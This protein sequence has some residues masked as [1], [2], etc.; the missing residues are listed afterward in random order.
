MKPSWKERNALEKGIFV[1]QALCG[2]V[3][4]A[5]MLHSTINMI[6]FSDSL[7]LVI[8]IESALEAIVQWK[9]QRKAAVLSLVVT[10]S[11]IVAFSAAM[12]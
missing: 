7:Y 9:R 8:A 5:S 12:F 6:D 2:L 10:I 11:C 1:V 3:L 4:I